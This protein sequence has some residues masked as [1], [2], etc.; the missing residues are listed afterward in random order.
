MYSSESVRSCFLQTSKQLQTQSA[1]HQMF[2]VK[3]TIPCI[4]DGSLV[5]FQNHDFQ[6][7]WQLYFI[8]ERNRLRLPKPQ[9]EHQSR[10]SIAGAKSLLNVSICWHFY[11]Y[12]YKC[13]PAS[14]KKK[15][16]SSVTEM[17]KLTTPIIKTQKHRK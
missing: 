13:R 9:I 1:S 14:S 10:N 17:Q 8:E 15:H 3:Q 12:E 7:I 11:Y 16:T 2:H 6:N 4:S 5:I